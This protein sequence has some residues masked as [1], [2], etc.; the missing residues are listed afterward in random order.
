MLNSIKKTRATG[1]SVENSPYEIICGVE[2][3]KQ[4]VLLTLESV[5]VVACQSQYRP[6]AKASTNDNPMS[7]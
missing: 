4:A 6:L 5:V 3:S 7:T 2:L 1:P